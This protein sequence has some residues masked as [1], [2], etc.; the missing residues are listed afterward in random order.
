M[1][2]RVTFISIIYYYVYEYVNV[3][4]VFLCSLFC[5]LICI[6][7]TLPMQF[8]PL[9]VPFSHTACVGLVSLLKQLNI[10]LAPSLFMLPRTLYAKISPWHS[11]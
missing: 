5:N 2:K 1:N 8:A 6:L 9:H 7:K 10:R 3:S 11:V 4:V